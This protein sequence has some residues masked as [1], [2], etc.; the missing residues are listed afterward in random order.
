MLKVQNLSKSFID[1]IL[2]ENM[3]FVINDGEKVGLVGPNGVGKTTLLRIIAG[4]ESPDTGNVAQGKLDH[5]AYL[6]QQAPSTNDSVEEYIRKSS[7]EAYYLLMRMKQLEQEMAKGASTDG[8]LIKEYGEVQDRFTAIDGW[9][10]QSDVESVIDVLGIGH[11]DLDS[12]FN[13]LSG[14]EQAR[15]LMAGVLIKNPTILLMDEPTNHLDT[16]G[17]LWLEKFL[18]EYSGI[19][20]VVSHDRKFLDKTVDKIYEL[21]GI[22]DELQV[23]QG[24]YTDYSVEKRQRFE[25]LAADY[26]A[27]E[28]YRKR[29]EADIQ[30][31]KNQAIQ[32]ENSTRND[33]ARRYAKKVAKKAKSRERRLSMQMKKAGWLAKPETRPKIILKSSAVSDKGASIVKFKEVSFS[34]DSRVVLREVSLD[35]KGR[36]RVVITGKNGS[37]KTT[38]MKL[39]AGVLSPTSGEVI[40]PK[41]VAYLPQDHSDINPD[42]SM[43]EYFRKN[44]TMY[45]DEARAFLIGLLFDPSQLTQKIGSL[46]P[47]ERSKL[48]L[49]TMVNSGSELI[50]LDE[51]TNHLDF[52]SLEVV[53]EMI[54][55]FKGTLVFIS[56]DRYFIERLNPTDSLHVSGSHVNNT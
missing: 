30:K 42:I 6:P 36:Q 41:N 23:Y 44:V 11:L 49:G 17:I 21:D 50:L 7:G 14:G 20:L 31:T 15:I 28:K 52:D 12:K 29:L 54:R 48:I 46:S 13:Q 37:G 39:M 24:G 16:D 47:G 35:I 40:V 10:I 18:S 38:L 33:V 34:F 9:K 22:Q 19:L 4:I 27:Q 8:S 26:E 32:V 25:K 3:N 2:F 43:L 45:E 5:I 55:E 51:P 1:T 53:E 56:H